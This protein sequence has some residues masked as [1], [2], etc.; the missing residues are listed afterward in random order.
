MNTNREEKQREISELHEK[1]R[2]SSVAIL[3]EFN[4][5]DVSEITELR[6]KLRGVK[7]ELRVVKNTLARRAV[8][9]TRMASTETAFEGPI[10]VTFGYDD[11]VAPAKID[12]KSVV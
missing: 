5:L 6:Q 2:S 9:G 4:G 10:A 3:M 1:F 12:R 11:P 8:E 7:G